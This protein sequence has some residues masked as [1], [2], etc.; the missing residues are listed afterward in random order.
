MHIVVWKATIMD[1]TGIQFWEGESYD[2]DSV[3]GSF[4]A[5]SNK[6]LRGV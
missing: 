3:L 6:S 5:I 4:N 1:E 2:K